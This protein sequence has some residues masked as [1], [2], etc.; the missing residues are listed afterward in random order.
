MHV[1]PVQR[2]RHEQVHRVSGERRV[3]V[4]VVRVDEHVLVR[5]HRRLRREEDVPAAEVAVRVADDHVIH[6]PSGVR[7]G[8]HGERIDDRAEARR[9][10]WLRLA[11]DQH[12]GAL[13]PGSHGVDPVSDDIQN[14]LASGRR[15][16]GGANVAEVPVMD[17]R[18]H[19]AFAINMKL[20]A[21]ERL[22]QC[23]DRHEIAGGY[24]EEDTG[25]PPKLDR[26]PEYRCD[27][28]RAEILER[29][30]PC[31]GETV[32]PIA[33]VAELQHEQV[34]GVVAV[35]PPYEGHGVGAS[36]VIEPATRHQLHAAAAL[37]AQQFLD[38]LGV[39]PLGPSITVILPA[40]ACHLASGRR[41]T[42]N[43]N[44][45]RDQL[46]RPPAQKSEG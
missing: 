22:V 7:P 36:T 1:D 35:G 37:P 11:A 26:T 29:G 41:D 43:L 16:A 2:Q 45:P 34:G 39:E 31:I 4:E 40:H 33:R 12:A 38:N 13:A 28:A 10:S 17:D 42:D 5:V 32:C 19:D 30:V 18:V 23:L 9:P 15:R 46:N 8:Q 21:I 44:A 3:R 14:E 27:M 6:E 20:L 25:H 24:L